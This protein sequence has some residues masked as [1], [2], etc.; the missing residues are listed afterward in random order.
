MNFLEYL[1]THSKYYI[2]VILIVLLVFVAFVIKN[3]VI[4]KIIIGKKFKNKMKTD[5]DNANNLNNEQN[6]QVE[7]TT[8]DDKKND[9][10]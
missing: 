6:E 9:I 1:S 2:M 10:E 8:L 7:Q 4:D 3:F 5:E